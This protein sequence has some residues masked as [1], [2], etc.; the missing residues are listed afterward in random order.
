M[1][2]FSVDLLAGLHLP[3]PKQTGR[4]LIIRELYTNKEYVPF[5]LIDYLNGRF[6]H[7]A[8]TDSVTAIRLLM[9]YSNYFSTNCSFSMFAVK[10]SDET[11]EDIF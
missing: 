11:D 4:L 3:N 6:L 8:H 2:Q 5:T 1:H 10:A 9:Q 7:V